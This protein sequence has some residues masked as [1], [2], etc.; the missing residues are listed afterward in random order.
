MA[1]LFVLSSS[2]VA[3]GAYKVSYIYVVGRFSD[4]YL[5]LQLQRNTGAY[6][7]DA[8]YLR[9]RASG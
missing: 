1:F 3:A 7:A 2:P 5:D 9:S 8:G 6:Q 4:E